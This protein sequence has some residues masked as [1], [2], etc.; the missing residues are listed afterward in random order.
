MRVDN[1][2]NNMDLQEYVQL[3]VRTESRIEKVQTDPVTLTRILGAFIY[4]GNL[5][6]MIKKGVFYKK[7]IDIEK[8]DHNVAL[9][10]E[11]S[12]RLA[13]GEY[14]CLVNDEYV[15]PIDPRVFHAIV[16][17]ATEA[18]ELVEALQHQ[19]E[20]SK[21]LDPVNLREEGLGDVCWYQAILADALGANWNDNLVTNI[22]KLKA[23]YPDRFTSENAIN[24]DLETEREILEQGSK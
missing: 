17:I 16:G 5:L 21:Q 22:A 3:A 10:H 13:G 15:Q 11:V 18:T 4:S 9:L 7:P 6:D 8:W 14:P 20:Q 12:H 19:L 24:R 2:E 1:K 23:R